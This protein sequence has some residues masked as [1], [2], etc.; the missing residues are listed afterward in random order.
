MERNMNPYNRFSLVSSSVTA[1]LI[2]AI[3]ALSGPGL[4]TAM[5][6]LESTPVQMGIMAAGAVTVLVVFWMAFT[7]VILPSLFRLNWV[8]KMILGRYYI[9]GTWLQSEKGSDASHI[10]VIDIQP[11]GKAFTFSGYALDENLEVNSNVL[12][13]LSRFDWPFLTYKYRNSLSDGADGQRD[14]V[15]EVQFEMNR[16]AAR[17]YN[18]YSQYIKNDQRIRLE[19]TKLVQNADVKRLRTL[20]GREEIVDKYWDLFFGRQERRLNKIRN[21]QPV[22]AERELPE[23][24]VPT[25]SVKRA[26]KSEPEFETFE[27]ADFKAPEKRAEK[28]I[29]NDELVLDTPRASEEEPALELT[30]RAEA[31]LNSDE[32]RKAMGERPS[33]L[34]EHVIPRRRASDWTADTPEEDIAK[35]EPGEMTETAEA[36]A[37]NAQADAQPDDQNAPQKPAD[38]TAQTSQT[39]QK[40]V[41]DARHV[42]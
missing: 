19:G 6:G 13:E 20:E 39:G 10:A 15:G 1:A 26:E 23:V 27:T 8:R 28:E 25:E 31:E 7:E 24:I 9:E 35:L 30:T 29:Q 22:A 14:G 16:D 34:E 33:D 32:R 37:Q 3:L 38:Q 5:A 36:A 2:L 12:L 42:M 11:N 41:F 4:V 18:G 40:R 21:M 17:R